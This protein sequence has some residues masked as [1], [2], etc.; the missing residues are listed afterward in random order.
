VHFLL[1]LFL[2]NFHIFVKNSVSYASLRLM[3]LMSLILFLLPYVGIITIAGLC[4]YGD[5]GRGQLSSE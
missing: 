2:S 3:L 5:G 1:E 4:R